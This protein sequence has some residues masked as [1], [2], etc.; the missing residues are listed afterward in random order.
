M[1]ID[2]VSLLNINIISL[3]TIQAHLKSKFTDENKL[4]CLGLLQTKIYDAAE[5]RARDRLISTKCLEFSKYYISLRSL[6]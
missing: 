5:D 2:E 1:P 4:N 6:A 3:F